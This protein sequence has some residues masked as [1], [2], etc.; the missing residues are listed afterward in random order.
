MQC[1]YYALEGLSALSNTIVAIQQ[2]LNPALVIEGIVRTMFDPRNNLTQQVSEQLKQHFNDVLYRTVIP[3]NIRLAEAP[4]HGL[5]V[6]AYDKASSGAQAADL[7]LKSLSTGQNPSETLPRGMTPI[8]CQLKKSFND[9]SQKLNEVKVQEMFEGT[10]SYG[11]LEY[12][13]NALEKILEKIL[14]P[15]V[16]LVGD[17]VIQIGTTLT[18]GMPETTE[19][20]LFV[21]PDCAPI[22]DIIV[23]AYKTEKAMILAWIEWMVERNPDILIGYNVF[24][25]DE[26]YVWHRAEEL[27]LINSNSPIHQFTRLFALSG[28]VKLEEKFLSSSAL[29]DNRMYIWTTQGRLQVDLF[30]YIKRNNVLPSYKL[31]E[32][33]KHFMSGK[34]KG[35]LYSDGKLV[36]DVA[37]AIKDVKPGRAITLLDDT[38]ET[39]SPKLVVEKV[40]GN[41]ISFM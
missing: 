26:S 10:L 20:H 41:K 29:G 9:I 35:Q 17:P 39:V 23:H 16:Y 28:E 7:I 37:G 31:D 38:G 32:V 1:E 12:R 25:F 2:S 6:I 21:F 4:S 36:L 3:R 34:L 5:P 15:F 11:D 30:H 8:Y 18:R 27:G 13:V 14:K 33:T 19:R 40:D 22:P 24:G